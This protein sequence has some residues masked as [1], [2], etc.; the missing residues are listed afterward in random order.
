MMTDPIADMLTRIRNANA[1]ERPAVD[2]PATKLK[3]A[4]AQVL[5]QEGF[6]LDYQVGQ[7]TVDEQGLPIFREINDFSVPKLTLR[8]YLKYGPEG[9]KVIRNIDRVSK[10]GG[11][12]YVRST[13]VRPVLQGLGIS[14]ISTSKGVLSDRQCRAQK[15][16]GEMLAIV[17]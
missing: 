15:L 2:M 7:E 12:R 10:P 9:E 4:I 17:W 1:I 16:G 14:I 6:I 3:A 11:R 13:E 8:V 5:K